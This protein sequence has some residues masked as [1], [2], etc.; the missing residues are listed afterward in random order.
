MCVS[1]NPLAT[2]ISLHRKHQRIKDI[3]NTYFYVECTQDDTLFKTMVLFIRSVTYVQTVQSHPNL[4]VFLVERTNECSNVVRLRNS[5]VS[6]CSRGK[7][8]GPR[9][10]AI[11]LKVTIVTL[12]CS[13]YTKLFFQRSLQRVLS[14]YRSKYKLKRCSNK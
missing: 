6:G 11:I 1:C 12:F 3:S 13:F 2:T 8:L 9:S 5:F 7:M 4:N 10:F 14:T